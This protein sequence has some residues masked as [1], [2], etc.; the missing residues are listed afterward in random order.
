MGWTEGSTSRASL[1]LPPRAPSG[2]QNI[3]TGWRKQG[4][5]QTA[6]LPPGW[7][8]AHSWIWGTLSSDEGVLA[9]K[10]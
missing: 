6:L 9:V 7:A 5:A 1:L 3:L 2:I 8:P 4:Q 10:H